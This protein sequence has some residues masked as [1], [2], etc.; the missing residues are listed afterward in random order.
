MKI[1]YTKDEDALFVTLR[2][3]RRY[4]ESEEVAPGVVLDFDEDGNV[5]ALEIYDRASEKANLSV[6]ATEGL[7]AESRPEPGD[8]GSKRG[9]GTRHGG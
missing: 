3:D 8:G 9:V 6:L 2:D 4:S 7:P 5:V 1:V